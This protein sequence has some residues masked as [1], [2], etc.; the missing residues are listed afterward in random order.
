MEDERTRRAVVAHIGQ[1]EGERLDQWL[2][3]VQTFP[4]ELQRDI[5]DD[6]RA[7]SAIVEH[8]ERRTFAAFDPARRRF[9]F[10]RARQQVTLLENLYPDSAAALRIQ[11]EIEARRENALDRLRDRFN[12]Y[13]DAGLLIPDEGRQ[14]IGDVLDAVR[15]MAPK[16]DLLK[17]DRLRLRYGELADEARR[18]GNHE[19]ATALVRAGLAYAPDDPAL[20]DLRY[21]VELDLARAAS[22]QRAAG[23][24]RRVAGRL[25]DLKNMDAFAV[26]HDDLL[27]L[28][29]LDPGSATLAR[30]RTR[31]EK[32]MDTELER[33]FGARDYDEA[34]QMLVAH[35]PLLSLEYLRAARDRLPDAVSVHGDGRLSGI[36]DDARIEERINDIAARLDEP[37][38]DSA[39]HAALER[40]YKELLVLLPAEHEVLHLQRDI[41]AAHFLSEARRARRTAS[42]NE[43]RIFIDSGRV[44]HPGFPPFDVETQAL[45][46]ARAE[47][48]ARRDAERLAAQ[49]VSLKAEFRGKAETNQVQEA[50]SLL[51]ELRDLGLAENDP[52]LLGEAPHALAD[53]YARLAASRATQQDYTG[54]ASL[55]RAG[56]RQ[57][58]EHTELRARLAGYEIALENQRFLRALRTRMAS[59]EPLDVSDTA[60]ALARLQARY[61]NRYVELAS[62]LAALR[63]QA[64]LEHARKAEP[65]AEDMAEQLSTFVALFPAHRGT[66]AED[67]LK[68]VEQRMRRLEP[69]TVADVQALQPI[70]ENVSRLPPAE[71]A[72]LRAL[73]AEVV[74]A[75]AQRRGAEDAEE[76]RRMLSTAYAGLP[77]QQRLVDASRTLPLQEL[78]NA[79][80]NL[81]AGSLTGAERDLDAAERK[82]PGHPGIAPLRGELDR[83]KGD[84]RRAYAGYVADI[85]KAEAREQ[86]RF[87]DRHADILA[88]WGDT[89]GFER[90]QISTP[91]QGECHDTLAGYGARSGGTC[92]DLVAGRKG[93]EMVVVPAGNGIDKAYA[94]GKY[95]VSV[96][97]FNH[98][99]EHSR[100]CAARNGSE[101]RN[102][103]TGVSVDDAEDYARWLSEE[104][105][106]NNG[107]RV[108]Y[109]L[110]TAAEW[111]HAARA[112]GQQPEQKFNCRVVSAGEV[113]AGHALVN[114]RSGKQN[115]WGLANYAGNAREWVR[116][117]QSLAVRGG[118]YDDPLTNCG[119]E[120][121]ETHTGE[122]DD[123]TGFRLVR[124]LG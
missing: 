38:A 75:G 89:P 36:L 43:A 78:S 104:A 35:A 115:G 57:W 116:N 69:G 63:A 91:R 51:L 87:D 33:L 68:A 73:L 18:A 50:K 55:A 14:Y 59:L 23:V 44:F 96:I 105:S 1:A 13:L 76:A 84:A 72:S 29:E 12:R 6:E 90:L 85:D 102:P 106:K 70:T 24:E 3:F 109:R 30:A 56:L 19:R 31:L 80:Q 27:V 4:P 114:A 7:R 107:H 32:A 2:A 120:L 34:W 81:S 42:F 28:A 98:F 97:D 5:L 46:D 65:V 110:P 52:F 62:E 15:R 86:R 8:F 26:H 88:M 48:R 16:D 101:R 95:E 9:D 74:I 94:I 67:L 17:D 118:A 100:R 122:A 113:I 54:A 79:R 71:R 10:A 121:D 64:V 45:A 66:L 21:Q 60:A 117:P 92:Y 53:A 11:T 82:A 49:V 58:P 103:L 47:L 99:C 20:N 40:P 77:E 108:V 22:Q 123:L 111:E 124:E 39:W 41:I 93:P 25:G 119:P 37:R 83:A 112:D 61:P